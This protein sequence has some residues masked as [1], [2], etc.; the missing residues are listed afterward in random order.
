[1][2]ELSLAGNRIRELPEGIGRLTELKRLQMSGN[3]LE[4]LPDS[5]CKC[6]ALQ[7]CA[8]LDIRPDDK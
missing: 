1:M 6:T 4:R 7:V 8:H 3:L 5:I 2:Q